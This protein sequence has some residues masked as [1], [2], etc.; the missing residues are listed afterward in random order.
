VA[1]L[2]VPVVGCE[3]MARFGVETGWSFAIHHRV[4]WSECDPFGHTNHRAY[5]EWFEEARNRYLE[6][7]R[8]EPLSPMTPGPVIAE[9]GIRYYRP[10]AYAKKILVS[11]R[12]VRL[13][14][15]SF[16]MEYAV[17]R[18]GLCALGRAMLILMVNATGQKVTLSPELRGRILSRDPA[19]DRGAEQ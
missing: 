1:L 12:A 7:V 3:E 13:G 14:R 5:F 19:L 15:T 18:D 16:E 6:A 8:L 9:T 17:W 2:S 4:R 10:L 11:A